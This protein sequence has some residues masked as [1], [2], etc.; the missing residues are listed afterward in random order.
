MAK[1]KEDKKREE[2]ISDNIVVDA[3]GED[4]RAL[5]K[6]GIIG[7]QWDT[8]FPAP[9]VQGRCSLEKKIL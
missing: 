5:R 3:Y 4:E 8:C 1:Q 7:W 6:T 2:R 9:A